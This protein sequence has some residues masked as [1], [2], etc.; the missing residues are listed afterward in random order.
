MLQVVIDDAALRTTAL[1]LGV[2]T[3]RFLG[4][5]FGSLAA[6]LAE[7]AHPAEDQASVSALTSSQQNLK[8]GT[9]ERYKRWQ[10]VLR[11]DFENLPLGLALMSMSLLAGA[12]PTVHAAAVTAFVAGRVLFTPCYVFGLQPFR[13]IAYNVGLAGI[14]AFAYNVVSPHL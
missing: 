13:S 8:A 9:S 7:G 10:N 4:T 11:N 1:G 6:S 5:T 12:D 2:L 3:V 14:L